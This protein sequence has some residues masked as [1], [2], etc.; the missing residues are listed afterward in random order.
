[1]NTH[2]KNYLSI[3]EKEIPP[4]LNDYLNIKEMQRLKGIGLF[5]GC[6]YTNLFNTRFF[7]SRFDHSLGVALIVWHFTHDKK[8]TIAG[9]LH[10]VSSPVFSHVV[11]F[12]NNDHLL[13]VSTEDE[14][15]KI[16]ENSQELLALLKR[17]GIKLE[18]VVDYKDYP[19]A[20]NPKPQLSADRL[21]YMLSTG[22][23]L[24]HTL[25]FAE[26]QMIYDDLDLFIDEQGNTE[27]GFKSQDIA[28]L[29]TH[30]CCEVAKLCLSNKNKLALQLL[31]DI[32]KKM[33]QKNLVTM[34]DFYNL[35]EAEMIDLIEKSEYQSIYQCFKDL[36]SIKESKEKVKGKYC[37]G[38]DVKKRYVNPLVQNK[39][40]SDLSST[41][42]SWID[43]L[44]QEELYA[45][46]DLEDFRDDH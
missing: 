12:L 6:D 9:L 27:I 43:N 32:L 37:I 7:Y 40:I 11:D 10:D 39:R 36:T 17:D 21:E 14:N 8:Q 3:Y 42:K 1:M 25:T 20:D 15:E 2:I 16:L 35:T 26:I 22:F 31:A 38:M 4:F 5:C 30:N 19:V 13:Q 28:T 24:T 33:A 45:Y 23:V 41:V 44:K 46:I 18:E 29:F 34:E